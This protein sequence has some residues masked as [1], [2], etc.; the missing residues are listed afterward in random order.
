MKTV[1]T[2]RDV[3]FNVDDPDL[4]SFKIDLYDDVIRPVWGK[5]GVEFKELYEDNVRNIGEKR[6]NQK[7][8]RDEIPPRLQILV[9]NIINRPRRKTET[10]ISRLLES[11][12]LFW[13]ELLRPNYKDEIEFI[14]QQWKS[15]ILGQW[16][17]VD[18][19]AVYITGDHWMYINHWRLKGG[20]RPEYRDRD[21]RWY[22]GLT[23]A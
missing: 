11:I 3:W 20:I 5:Y 15:R 22:Y 8:R 17:M 14:R 10:P 6:H 9:D 13:S 21:R 23:Y 16:Y 12:D 19:N 7:I 2:L 18:G 4:K 1:Y